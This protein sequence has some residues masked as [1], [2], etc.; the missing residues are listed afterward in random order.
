MKHDFPNIKLHTAF[1]K[2]R[3]LQNAGAHL[4]FGRQAYCRLMTWITEVIRNNIQND[5]IKSIRGAWWWFDYDR[6]VI[7]YRGLHIDWYGQYI[8]SR[9][10]LTT[11]NRFQS[12]RFECYSSSLQLF[13]WCNVSMQLIRYRK[14]N[15][16]LN[17]AKCLL[18][19]NAVGNIVNRLQYREIHWD[20][21]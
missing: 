6:G 5:R 9:V 2:A 19:L 4:F 8:L 20:S 13:M 14:T 17:P 10:F 7:I 11:T 15:W 16:P 12:N 3:L 1:K 18:F 21:S